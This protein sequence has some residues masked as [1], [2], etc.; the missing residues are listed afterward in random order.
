[1]K[2]KKK[3]LFCCNCNLNRSPT[4]AHFFNKNYPKFEIKSCGVY[5]GYPEQLNETILKWADKVYVMDLSQELFI[6][7]HY[8]EYLN[9]V[10]VIGV[11]DEYNPDDERLIE[12]IKYW[13]KKIQMQGIVFY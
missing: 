11:S 12:L 9:K 1:M 7:Q 13:I 3:L 5:Y 6:S 10:E 8:P 2:L 4:F